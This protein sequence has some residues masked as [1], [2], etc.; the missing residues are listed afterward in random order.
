VQE[1]ERLLR[2]YLEAGDGGDYAALERVLH[3]EVTTH[4]PGDVTT[5]GVDSQILAWKTA[6]EGLD[7]LRHEI[8]TVVA[9]GA[10]AA[11]RVRVSGVHRGTFLGVEPTEVP[12]EVDQALFLQ[13]DRGRVVEMWEIVDTGSGLRQL[14]LVGDQPLSPGV[15]PLG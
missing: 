2:E 5:H 8:E 10:S 13:T 9:S 6:H 3:S 15:G 4:S 12:I 7:D 1:A 11:A 14:G